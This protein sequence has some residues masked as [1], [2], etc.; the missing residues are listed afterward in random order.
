[1]K[2]FYTP[3]FHRQYK[4]LPAGVKKLV[5]EKEILFREDW[6]DPIL[7][8]HKLKGKLSGLWSFSVDNK[9]RIIFEC[10]DRETIYFHIIGDHG[11]Y[12]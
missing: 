5:E 10:P 11:I 2:I 8:T 12:D 4:K 7:K 1:M 3:Q 9:Y 6:H